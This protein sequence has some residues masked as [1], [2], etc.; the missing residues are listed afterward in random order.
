[1]KLM[2]QNRIGMTATVMAS[3]DRNELKNEMRRLESLQAHRPH[4]YQTYYF[5]LQ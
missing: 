2:K 4:C 5:I 3:N 1:M